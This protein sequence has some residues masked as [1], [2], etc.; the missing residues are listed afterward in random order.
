MKPNFINIFSHRIRIIV[1]E[2]FSDITQAKAKALYSRCF[3]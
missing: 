2:V 3:L 1:I